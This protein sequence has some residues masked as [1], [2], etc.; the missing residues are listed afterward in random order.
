MAGSV[1][2]NGPMIA[3]GSRAPLTIQRPGQ[4]AGHWAHRMKKARVGVG[5]GAAVGATK[6]GQP[7]LVHHR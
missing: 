6:A 5:V 1:G 4:V 7:T 2:L 3:A